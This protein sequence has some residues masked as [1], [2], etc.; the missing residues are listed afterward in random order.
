[1]HNKENQPNV[2]LYLLCSH[3]IIF[4]SDEGQCSLKIII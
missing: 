4:V 3:V 1:M 2:L